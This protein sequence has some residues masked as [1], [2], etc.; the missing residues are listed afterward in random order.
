MTGT[1]LFSILGYFSGSVLY[2]NVFGTIF[3]KKTLYQNSPDRN[4][5]TANAYIYGGFWCGTLTLIGDLLK[6]FLPVFLYLQL[7]PAQEKWGL[8]LVLAAPV[9]GHI[10]PIFNGFHGG[11]GIAVTFGCLLGLFPYN[12][13]VLLFAAVFIFLSVVLQISP[14]YYRTIAAYLLTAPAMVLTEV[15]PEV[16]AGFLLIT[17]SVCFRLY[18]SKEKKEHFRVKLLWLH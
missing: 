10:F 15:I 6:G 5:G 17:V 3:Q 16:W 14:H 9:I 11:K 12:L 18:L 4:P 13:P 2:A 1:V 8:S 7:A